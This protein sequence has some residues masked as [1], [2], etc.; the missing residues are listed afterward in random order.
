MYAKGGGGTNAAH[1]VGGLTLSPYG[2]ATTETE[3]WNGSTWSQ[4]ASTN[5]CHY[6]GFYAGI[7]N[8]AIMLV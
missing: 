6:L 8:D 1:I 3:C 2:Q 7:T 4:E 5:T